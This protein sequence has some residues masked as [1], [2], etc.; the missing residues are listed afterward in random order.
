MDS[1]FIV[2]SGWL[3]K[4]PPEKRL[5]KSVSVLFDIIVLVMRD[6]SFCYMTCYSFL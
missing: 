4:S 6:T 1:Q 5:W 3:T 2:V